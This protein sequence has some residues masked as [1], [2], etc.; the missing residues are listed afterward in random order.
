[1]LVKKA[2]KASRLRALLNSP[3][4]E[5]LCEVHNGLS[6]KIVEEAGFKGMW[7]SGLSI[8]AAL[9]V[10]DNN[11]ASWTEVLDVVDFIGEATSIPLLLDG[12]TGYGNFNNVRRLVKKL[13][14]MGVAGVAIEDKVFPK[15]NSFLREERQPLADMD[16]FA[17]KIKAAKDSQEDPDFCVVARVEALI[18]GWGLGE[19]LR[20]A[21]AYHK[22]GADAILIHSKKSV[23]DEVLAFQKE[24]AGRSPVVIVPTKYY[25]TP[26]DVFREAKFS[27]AIWANHL[28][29]SAAAAMQQTARQIHAE[30]TLL[31]VE[32]RIVPVSEIFR[33]Q[34]DAELED[35]EKRYLP[36][37]GQK[38]SAV[39]LAASRG[40]ELGALTEALP[41]ALLPVGG[42]PLLYRQVDTL[43]EVGIKDVTVV[44]G[45]RKELISAPNL[46]YADND[47]Y[48]TTQELASLRTGLTGA[49]GATLVA[50]GDILYKK[51][52]PELLLQASDD[53]LIAVDSDWESR[54]KEDR[55]GDFV[56]CDRA[57][58]KELF[59]HAVQ[60]KKMGPPAALP[61]AGTHGEWMGLLKLSA[62]GL[63][64]V[65]GV[66]AELSKRPDFNKL[67]M[68]EL[69]NELVRQGH[70]V[71]VQYI[72]GHWLDVDDISDLSAAGSF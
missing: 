3:E 27:V 44:R 43:N 71:K 39:I 25:S 18:A 5:F 13:G 10:R 72:R 69:F 2:S 63:K 8:S 21:E 17:G 20:R 45:F 58:K 51:Y 7:G 22:A 53:I 66:V 32:D 42:K 52:I 1:M 24:W 68:A 56:A 41:K 65:Q 48:A 14:Q 30:Q 26:T 6:A 40:K 59:D 38:V 54:R 35:A 29:R 64:A 60:L 16:E 28:V 36:G 62:K 9:G 15:T 55:Y 4:L 46:R 11:E 57:Y 31:N 12:D 61:R 67:R 70:P 33:L 34:G 50:Y 49:S 23:P 19:A 37:A 47:A